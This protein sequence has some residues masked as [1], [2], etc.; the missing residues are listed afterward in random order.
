M[1]ADQQR[2]FAH[3]YVGAIVSASLLLL[4]ARAEAALDL[5]D[6]SIEELAQ[7]EVTS[8]SKRAEPLSDAAAAI[9]V[10]THDDII[11]SGATAFPEILRLAPNLQ[12]AQI[13]A[14]HYAVSARGFNGGAADKLLVL[15]DGRS[16]Y[17]PFS[18]GVNWDLQEVP[19]DSIERIE[20]VSG[21]GGTLWGANAVNGVINI[22][23]RKSSDTQ[24][25]TV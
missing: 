21:P 1:A 11:R 3:A 25:V 13:T 20:V 22:I 15:V 18:S 16:I 14:S 10:I 23:T 2:N 4:S 12:V 17:T 19:P 6:M 5:S 24:C 8:V 9:Y 7:I